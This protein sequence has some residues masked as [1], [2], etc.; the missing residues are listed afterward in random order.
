MPPASAATDPPRRSP[1]MRS[2]DRAFG[3]WVAT[4]VLAGVVAGVRVYSSGRAEPNLISCLLLTAVS[5]VWAVLAWQLLRRGVRGGWTLFAWVCVY[6]AIH[7]P[8][9]LVELAI[10]LSSRN[11]QLSVVLYPH[12]VRFVNAFM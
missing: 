4:A 7:G 3:G 5:A 6:H 12:V 10:H 9:A 8:L 1:A 2:W 11:D